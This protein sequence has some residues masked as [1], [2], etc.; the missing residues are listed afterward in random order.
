MPR[1]GH[2]SRLDNQ[3][4]RLIRGDTKRPMATLK[5]W[6]AF[7]AKTGHC[8]HVT[9]ISQALH[10]SG[11][12]GAV[13][14]TKLWLKKA[15]LESHLRY[16]KRHYGDSEATWQKVLWCYLIFANIATLVK[17]DTLA[18]YPLMLWSTLQFSIIILNNFRISRQCVYHIDS[19]MYKILF[20]IFFPH[21]PFC[22]IQSNALFH[23]YETQSCIHVMV[24]HSCV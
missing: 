24:I 5:E 16:A 12:F 8:V 14:I 18:S 3:A 10:K 7:M 6:Q 1:S 11:L 19:F 15:H 22:H 4:R 9:T 23:I 13:A 21:N 2:P 17:A 20:F